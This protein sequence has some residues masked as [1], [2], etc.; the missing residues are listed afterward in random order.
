MIANNGGT[1]IKIF[2]YIKISILNWEF[3]ILKIERLKVCRSTKRQPFAG[4][5]VIIGA[6]K[7][8]APV[9]KLRNVRQF[10]SLRTA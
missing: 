1:I 10:A 2:F 3:D 9:E 4:N 6:L 8:L 7:S 5:E